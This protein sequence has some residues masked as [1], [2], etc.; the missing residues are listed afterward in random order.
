MNPEIKTDEILSQITA[1]GLE[2]GPKILA[3]VAVW[4]IGGWIITALSSGTT[5]LLNKNKH[6]SL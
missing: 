1:L 3:A 6:K 4:V 2:Y 5:K